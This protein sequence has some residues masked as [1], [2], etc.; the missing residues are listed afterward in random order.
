MSCWNG[1]FECVVYLCSLNTKFTLL[2]VYLCLY[3]K[4]IKLHIPF[5]EKSDFIKIF[6]NISRFA[7]DWVQN[8]RKHR[9]YLIY[10]RGQ[11][12]VWKQVFDTPAI[13]AD[14]N[15]AISSKTAK[16]RHAE[17]DRKYSTCAFADRVASKVIDTYKTVLNTN[18]GQFEAQNH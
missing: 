7:K 2:N 15:L 6:F 8:T 12:F 17:K 9:F 4:S 3:G 14:S 11:H 16:V 18:Q 1:V 13:M 5:R 10:H